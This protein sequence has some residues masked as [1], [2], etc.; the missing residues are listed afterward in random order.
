MELNRS[1]ICGVALAIVVL[2]TCSSLPVGAQNP[3]A[4]RQVDEI[5]LK[6]GDRTVR[7]SEIRDQL[8]FEPPELVARLNDD[9]NFARI[10]AVR[11]Y[12]AELSLRAAADDGVLKRVPGLEGAARNLGRNL[13][14]DEYSS[15]MM[16]VDFK[17]TD[18][19]IQSFYS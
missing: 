3:P 16:A 18:S 7:R 14:A 8:A 9:S 12:Q 10:Y 13:I 11:W 19:E 5:V 1:R 17:P 6:V 15:R 4:E 2:S